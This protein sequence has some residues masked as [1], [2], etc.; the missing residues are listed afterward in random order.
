MRGRRP[1]RAMAPG[2]VLFA[3]GRRADGIFDKVIIDLDSPIL[4][5]HLQGFPLVKRIRQ[6]LAQTALG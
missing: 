3:D 6:R 1:A 2:V 5:E 4:E